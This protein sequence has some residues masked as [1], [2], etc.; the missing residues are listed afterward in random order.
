MNDDAE[1][2]RQAE[3]I[4]SLLTMKDIAVLLGR[5][6]RTVESLRYRGKL[7]EPIKIPGL[8][9][10]RWTPEQVKEILGQRTGGN[11]V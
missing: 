7:P 11:K 6:V 3:F 9:G 5:P 4:R 1:L 8:I 10:L 2:E